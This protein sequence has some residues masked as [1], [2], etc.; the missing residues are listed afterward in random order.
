MNG[1]YLV[2]FWDLNKCKT[3]TESRYKLH[4][5]LILFYMQPSGCMHTAAKDF[6][7]R[8]E[9]ALGKIL[10]D[11][12]FSSYARITSQ[13]FSI[14]YDLIWISS[15]LVSLWLHSCNYNSYDDIGTLLTEPF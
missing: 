4:L 2:T 6:V 8:G 9:S 10:C 3:Q 14:E 5:R 11:Y 15:L 1:S 12:Y 7:G 13:L